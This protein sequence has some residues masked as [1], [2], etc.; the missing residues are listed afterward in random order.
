MPPLS[1]SNVNRI[2]PG[3]GDVFKSPQDQA[4]RRHQSV[5]VAD[6]DGN[7]VAYGDNARTPGAA[8]SLVI[9]AAAGV[10]G[11]VH[12]YQDGLAGSAVCL[13]LFNATSQPADTAVPE[14]R[15]PVIGGLANYWFPTGFQFSTGLVAVW[16]STHD[17]LTATVGGTEGYIHA[18]YS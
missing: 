7:P 9:K 10:V 11:E 13:M 17:V 14:W 6:A 1:D 4:G 18:R 8:D 2:N 15:I 3:T 12:A 5:V 16:S